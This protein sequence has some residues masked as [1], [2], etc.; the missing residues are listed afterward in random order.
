MRQAKAAGANVQARRVDSGEGLPAPERAEASSTPLDLRR[1]RQ[2]ARSRVETSIGRIRNGKEI[3]SWTI[4]QK[5]APRARR[6]DT[7][8]NRPSTREI[9][10]GRCLE[11]EYAHAGSH[12]LAGGR[13][14]RDVEL[15]ARLISDI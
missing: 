11:V 9:G 4:L 5:A 15:Q 7:Q 10:P 6:S 14:Y 13:G 12:T 2:H 3:G 8:L 1:C